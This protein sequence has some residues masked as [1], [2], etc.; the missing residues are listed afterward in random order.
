M[1]VATIAYSPLS[2]FCSGTILSMDQILKVLTQH[3]IYYK[4][5][6]SGKVMEARN[7]LER[8]RTPKH[9]C[10]SHLRQ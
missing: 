3:E 1:V 8:A 4:Y 6:S 10:V 5:P 2:N 7:S 9:V